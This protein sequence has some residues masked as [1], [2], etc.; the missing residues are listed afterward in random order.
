MNQREG[1]LGFDPRERGESDGKEKKDHEETNLR[2]WI[3]MA[4]IDI[5]AIVITATNLFTALAMQS[6]CHLARGL[7]WPNFENL[8]NGRICVCG[9][10]VRCMAVFLLNTRACLGRDSF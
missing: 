4:V 2:I 1:A 9:V 7:F 5:V 8:M 6:F 10:W 3:W